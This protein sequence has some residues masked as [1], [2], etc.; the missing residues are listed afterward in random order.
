MTNRE[1]LE[2]YFDTFSNKDINTL[3]KMFSNDV[4]LNDWNVSVSGKTEVVNTVK[5]IF[6]EV[7]SIK[8]TPLKIYS[9]NENSFAVE[10]TIAVN[11]EESYCSTLDVIDVIEFNVKGLIKSVNAYKV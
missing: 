11:T 2:V 8:V 7:S 6:D 10:T 9:M 5:N 1:K 3:S 4:V